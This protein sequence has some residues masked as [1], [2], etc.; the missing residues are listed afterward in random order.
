MY[1]GHF[2]IGL[3]IKAAAPRTP[4]LPILMGVGLL[5]LLDGIFI[6]L[7]IDRVAPNLASG[8]Y[9]YFDLLFI[10]WDHSLLMAV[11]LSLVWGAF[12][13]RDRRVAAIAAA[14][15]FSHWLAD[16]PV[17][18]GDL[19]AYPHSVEHYGY[20]LWGK[21]GMGSWLLEGLFAAVLLAYAWTANA[22]RGVGTLW[23]AVV[24]V[25]LFLQLSPW[26][27]PMKI[28][29]RFDEPA[30]HLA[31]GALVALGFLVPAL[32]LTWLVD[33]AERRM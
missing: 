28:V 25:V 7:G 19:A 5:D 10:D 31:H 6:V 23:P 8:P 33:R 2:A 27:S 29:A 24:L 30:A 20:G 21:L 13:L 15:V 12:F 9:L 18:N 1:A 26:L 16:W 3:A 22:R 32:L 17:H 11:V 4:A 14:A